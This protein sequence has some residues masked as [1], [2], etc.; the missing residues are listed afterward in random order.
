M[1]H[2]EI[3]AITHNKFLKGK[4]D[5]DFQSQH[6]LTGIFSALKDMV[7]SLN[8]RIKVA[9]E[10]AKGNWDIE[11]KLLSNEDSLGLALQKMLAELKERDDKL[12]Q[13]SKE[14]SA[15]MQDIEQTKLA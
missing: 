3:M 10:I 14:K 12:L 6:K 8:L 15:V 4:T 1:N 7:N 9:Q 2:L 13:E 5:I 11:V